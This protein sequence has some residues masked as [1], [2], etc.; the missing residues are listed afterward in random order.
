VNEIRAFRPDLPIIIAS[1]KNLLE[2]PA[3]IERHD[4]IVILHK[5]YLQHDFYAALRSIGIAVKDIAN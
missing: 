4:R 2:L 5:P 3:G 1:G